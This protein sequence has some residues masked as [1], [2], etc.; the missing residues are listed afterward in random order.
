METGMLRLK[1]GMVHRWVTHEWGSEELT[2]LWY[3]MPSVTS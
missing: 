3:V 1:V 2:R